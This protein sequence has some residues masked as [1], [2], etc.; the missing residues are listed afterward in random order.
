MSSRL[1]G[2]ERAALTPGDQ[3][4]VM[5]RTQDV[6]DRTIDRRT[7]GAVA[8]AVVVALLFAGLLA[9]AGG[10]QAAAVAVPLGTAESF[11]VL[12]G[13]TVTNTGPS[14]INGDLGLAPGTAVTGF[15]PGTVQDGTI[16]VANAVAD[17][18]KQDLVTA[19]DVAAGQAADF[20]L[21][22]ELGGETLVPG[23]STPPPR[24]ASPARSR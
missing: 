2:T 14:T 5:A 9:T 16:H 22:P 24:S 1:Q 18:A 8:S 3:V 12:A 23:V 15:P 4:R 19:Y 11:A 6:V 10:A 20:S 17:Q 7:V 21:D 13:S